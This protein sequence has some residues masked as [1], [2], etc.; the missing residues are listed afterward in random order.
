MLLVG[1]E[2]TTLF[3]FILLLFLSAAFSGTETALTSL[4]KIKVRQLLEHHGKRA[5]LLELWIAHPERHL[6]T[7][8]ICN[9]LVNAGATSMATLV[10]LSL[11][12]DQLQ[13]SA[14]ILATGVMTFLLL[15]F[16]EITP[17]HFCRR[18][19]EWFALH[20]IWPLE[21]LT[22]IL[23]P[24]E[25]VLSWLSRSII[26]LISFGRTSTQ[27]DRGDG[28][29]VAAVRLS[30]EEGLIERR[31]QSMIERV[32]GLDEVVAR[33]IMVPRMKMSALSLH[34]TREEI[35]A[36]VLKSGHRRFPLYDAS[37]DDI[38]GV[39]HTHDLLRAML[40]GAPVDL[41]DMAR[42]PKFIPETK[43]VDELLPFFQRER[44]HMALVINEYGGIE[45]LL[46]LE[47]VIEEIVGEIVDEHDKVDIPILPLSDGSFRLDGATELKLVERALSIRIT[48]DEASLNGL[49]TERLGHLPI[50]G[51][52]LELE[53]WRFEVI[54]ATDRMATAIMATPCSVPD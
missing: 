14:G 16:G 10:A 32:L 47:D 11:L 34:A 54:A 1:M 50:V 15:V 53:G 51:D 6:T 36:I 2:L 39:L 13:S 31:E 46:T 5:R 26:Y 20:A 23:W 9:N 18:H 45:G 25:Q 27:P 7:L 48:G 37:P 49:L 12:G 52:T 21:C 30:H 8:L 24:I 19:A 17:K 22:R 4:G 33:Q 41:R 38:I 29:L 40:D 35:A 3:Y 42:P 44:T 43:P 28:E